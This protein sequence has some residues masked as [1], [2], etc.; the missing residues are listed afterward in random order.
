MKVTTDIKKRW[1]DLRQYGDI[2]A[3]VKKSGLSRYTIMAAMDGGE[4]S[5][6]AFAY[7]Q[8]F[9]NDRQTKIDKLLNPSEKAA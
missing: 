4:C 6:E 5:M 1:N 8:N 3:I 2:E 7:I 9:Y